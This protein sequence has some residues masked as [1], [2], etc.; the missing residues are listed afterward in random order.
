MTFYQLS[1]GEFSYLE[2]FITTVIE[3]AQENGLAGD[4]CLDAQEVQEMLDAVRNNPV[5]VS[6]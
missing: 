1:K 2:E 5:D 3:V 4:L 6:V